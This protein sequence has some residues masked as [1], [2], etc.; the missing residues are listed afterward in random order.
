MNLNYRIN[1]AGIEKIF[2]HLNECNIYFK[3]LLTSRVD[4]ASYARKVVSNAVRCEAWDRDQLVGLVATYMNDEKKE[5]AFITNVSVLKNYWAQGIATLL[6]R[7]SMQMAKEL[8]YAKMVLEVTPDN[9][10]AVAFYEKM[11]FAVEDTRSVNSLT[12]SKYL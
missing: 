8:G 5:K 11:E 9:R 3:P 6:L 4:I 1:N 7:Q 12:M 10:A 2:E